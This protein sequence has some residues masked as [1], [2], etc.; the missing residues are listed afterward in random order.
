MTTEHE[1]FMKQA[2]NLASYSVDKGGGPFGCV[3]VDNETNTIIGKGHN[4]VTLNN[5]PTAHAEVVAIRD[6]CKT[7][8]T[9][10]LENCT[11]YTSCEPCP[12]CLSAIYWARIN[13]VYCGNTCSDA[14][15]IGFDDRFIYDEIAK[16]WDTRS[17]KMKYICQNYARIAFDKWRDFTNKTRY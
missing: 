2:C 10:K 13:T 11:L 5:D 9:F 14:A 16:S 15:T 17:I 12:M 6:A 7:L 8:D 3:I 4:Q 1:N